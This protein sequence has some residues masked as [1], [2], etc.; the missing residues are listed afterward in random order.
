MSFPPLKRPD[1]FQVGRFVHT[2][3]NLFEIVERDG[4]TVWLEDCRTELQAAVDVD[5]LH[6]PELW[7]LLPK[8]NPT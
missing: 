2:C 4:D 8:T 7:T 6:D 3:R 1:P 5:E